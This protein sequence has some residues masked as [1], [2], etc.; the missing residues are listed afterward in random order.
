MA[1][2]NTTPAATRPP[3]V[4]ATDGTAEERFARHVRGGVQG[5]RWHH[6]LGRLALACCPRGTPDRTRRLAALAAASPPCS[7]S[8]LHKVMKFAD[9]YTMAEVP[10]LECTGLG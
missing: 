4:P 5:L 7:L 8:L 9:Q 10:S 2:T 1:R 3:G 6:Q